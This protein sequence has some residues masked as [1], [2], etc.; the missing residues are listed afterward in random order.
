MSSGAG[1]GDN[2]LEQAE[3]EKVTPISFG[4]NPLKKQNVS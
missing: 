3:I 4:S 2:F 1:A